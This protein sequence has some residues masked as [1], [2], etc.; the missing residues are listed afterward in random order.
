MPLIGP[1]VAMTLLPVPLTVRLNRPVSSDESRTVAPAL[2][3][4]LCWWAAVLLERFHFLV[5]EVTARVS[6]FVLFL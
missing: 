5:P 6:V 4:G 1:R 2:I 3:A